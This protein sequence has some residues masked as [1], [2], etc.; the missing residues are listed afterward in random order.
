VSTDVKVNNFASSASQLLKNHNPAITPKDAAG[1]IFAY[2]KT[3]YMKIYYSA[4]KETL[5]SQKLACLIEKHFSGNA[6]FSSIKHDVSPYDGFLDDNVL[7]Q[8]HLKESK[9]DGEF[10]V[11][12]LLTDEELF[13]K[14]MTA[15]TA[16]FSGILK[17][18]IDE[19][20]G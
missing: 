4:D 1:I 12:I 15:K 13:S 17:K 18:A 9:D 10:W 3:G 16:Q 20:Y 5:S 11:I 14:G 8:N 6:E 7:F 2:N 19:Y